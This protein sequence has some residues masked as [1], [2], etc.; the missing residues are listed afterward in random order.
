[1]RDR[2][3]CVQST[4]RSTEYICTALYR[5]EGEKRGAR[6]QGTSPPVQVINHNQH[7]EMIHVG[8][9]SPSLPSPPPKDP[10]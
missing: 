10:G 7:R 6:A 1:M 3:L 2:A 5:K 8:G 4:V 9:D